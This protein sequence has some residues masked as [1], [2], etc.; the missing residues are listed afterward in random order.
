MPLTMLSE[1]SE[2]R[3]A[4]ITVAVIAEY[5]QKYGTRYPFHAAEMQQDILNRIAYANQIEGG[6]STTAPPVVPPTINYGTEDSPYAKYMLYGLG[7]V[8]LLIAYKMFF[9]KKA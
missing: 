6:G 8:G 7:A 1:I 9:M 5:H 3:K 2:A 4:E